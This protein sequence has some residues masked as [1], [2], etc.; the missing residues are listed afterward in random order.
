MLG[1]HDIPPVNVNIVGIDGDVRFKPDESA[2]ERVGII[3][4]VKTYILDPAGVA[5][6][7]S[8]PV[9]NYNPSRRRISIMSID[10]A[11]VVYVGTAP[12]VSPDTS[13]VTLAPSNGAH[14]PAGNAYPW[15]S[16]TIENVFVNSVA[17]TTSGRVTVT[18]EYDAKH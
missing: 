2:P 13:T 6:P 12:N 17:G 15:E 16:R 5:G 9:G 4:V 18:Q 11:F 14:W 10:K 8:I 3:T 7:T 1:E